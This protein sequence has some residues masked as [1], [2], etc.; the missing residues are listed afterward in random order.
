MC[1]G[2]PPNK[3]RIAVR[4]C[5][6][7]GGGADCRTRPRPVLNHNRRAERRTH[8]IR[9]GAREQIG[10]TARSVRIDQRDRAARKRLRS[11]PASQQQRG[12]P[13]NGDQAHHLALPVRP[14]PAIGDSVAPDAHARP[15][16]LAH[17]A[18]QLP[19]HETMI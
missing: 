13:C 5:P 6:R 14:E 8:A 19:L 15:A 18:G 16:Q 1:E 9:Y 2:D 4:L 11:C 17:A 12:G 7:D 3:K 10:R